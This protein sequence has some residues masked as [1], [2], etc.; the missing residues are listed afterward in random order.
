ML[1]RCR[2]TPMHNR[3]NN[4]LKSSHYLLVILIRLL[5]YWLDRRYLERFSEFSGLFTKNLYCEKY[6][7]FTWFP[8]VE[9]LR[10]GSY[11][12]LVILIRLLIYWLDRRYLERISEFSGLSTRNLYCEKYRNFTWFPNVEILRKGSYYLLVILI[13]LLI[14]W[15]DRRYLERISEFSGLSTRNLYCEKYRNFTWFRDV[16]ILRKGTVSA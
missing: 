5:V 13:R 15:L 14:Y 3:V 9:I 2:R 4:S 16:E 12:L 6:R 1:Y 8:N 7:N 10:K 11:Y